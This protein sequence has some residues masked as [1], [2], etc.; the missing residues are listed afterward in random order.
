MNL[1]QLEQPVGHWRGSHDGRCQ[2]R[3]HCGEIVSPVEAV[4]EFGEV[5]RDMLAAD[6]AV[7]SDNCGLDI[8]EGGI[9]PAEGRDSSRCGTRAGYDDLVRAAGVLDA[10]KALKTVADH[11]AVRVEA[12]LGECRDGVPAK[13]GDAPQFQADWLAVR[14]GFNRGDERRFAGG[15]APALASGAFAAECRRRRVRH[16][17]SRACRHRV[18]A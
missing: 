15:A 18:R 14:R 10:A 12:A 16:A 2:A 4:F 1:S 7:G 8:A 11:R 5:A 9:D 17:R 6:G 3:D 13:A